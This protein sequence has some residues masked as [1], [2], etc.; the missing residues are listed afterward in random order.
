HPRLRRLLHGPAHAWRDAGGRRLDH[1][2]R[3]GR[4]DPHPRHGLLHAQAVPPHLP[5]DLMGDF[6]LK[7]Q[8]DVAEK[9]QEVSETVQESVAEILGTEPAGP[10][11]PPPRSCLSPPSPCPAPGRSCAA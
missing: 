2:V 1:A 10:P 5:G 7:L 8:E 4:L 9:L 6:L 11:P 3:R